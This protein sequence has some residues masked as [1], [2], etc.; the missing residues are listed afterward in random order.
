M[1][2]NLVKTIQHFSF[3]ED[4]WRKGS[5]II[6]GVSGGPDSACLLAILAGLAPKYGL[7]LV[8][9]HVNYG[10]RGK[11]SD[12][13]EKFV[14]ELAKKYGLK[15]EVL[16]FSKAKLWKNLKLSFRKLPSENALR[17]I[18]YAFFEKIRKENN[19]DLIAVA[20]NQDD[21]AETVLMR[22]IRGAGMKGLSGIKAKNDRIIR[23]LLETSRKEI[24][25]HL[26][27][28]DLKFRTD[29]TNKQNLFLRNKIRNRLIPY[30]EQKF[31]PNIKRTLAESASSI[32]DDDSFLEQLA[33]KYFW[34]KYHLSAKKLLS[35]DLSL[36]KRV[37]LL[38]IREKRGD[39]ENIQ[40]GHL[41]EIIKSLKSTKSKHQI[42]LFQGLKLTRKGDKVILS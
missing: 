36:Q 4:L 39:L 23:P 2:K 37:L 22:L 34:K 31:N 20:H 40:A 32:A 11:D 10:L 33:Q 30:I 9:A 7:E 17:D 27:A 1:S 26:R 29:R 14:R 3:Q 42:V 19:F 5:R 24:L 38:A 16:K 35:L 12:R 41:R 6:L 15:I 13:D 18:R 28:N 8:I 25:D 21:Q